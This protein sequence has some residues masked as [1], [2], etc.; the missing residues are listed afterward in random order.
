[1]K[2]PIN[3]TLLVAVGFLTITTLEA[4]TKVYTWKDASGEMH[5]SA[6]PPKPTEKVSSLKDDMRI[7]DNKENTDK[8]LEKDKITE[9]VV[10]ETQK[11]RDERNKRLKYCE[12]QYKNIELLK[13]N[14]MVKWIN[15]D[16]KSEILTTEQRKFKLQS[17]KINIR[18][19]CSSLKKET[20]NNKDENE[21]I[22]ANNHQ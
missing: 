9:N 14:K 15:K 2:L 13:S 10:N 11:N 4:K 19:N 16:G 20:E 6:F 1:M 21:V 5:Y 17:L 3:I 18:N 7:P 8:S 22:N 12:N